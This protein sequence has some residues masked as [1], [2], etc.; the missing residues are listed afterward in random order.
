[1][2]VAPASGTVLSCSASVGD[3]LTIGN[4]ICRIRTAAVNPSDTYLLPLSSV[5][6]TPA[7]SFVFLVTEESAIEAVQVETGLVS[8][9]GIVVSGLFGDEFIVQDVRGLKAGQTVRVQ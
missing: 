3:V 9:N 2:F 5:K 7:G 1:M 8:Q 4:D 6:Y